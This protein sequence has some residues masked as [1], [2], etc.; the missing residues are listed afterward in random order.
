M[1]RAKSQLKEKRSERY[2]QDTKRREYLQRQ[3][4]LR[5]DLCQQTRLLDLQTLA[6]SVISASAQ[7][8]KKEKKNKKKKIHERFERKVELVL[9]QLSNPEWM[10]EIPSD[11]CQ[12]S[13]AAQDQGQGD[14][15]GTSSH[16]KYNWYVRPR[17][18]GKRCLVIASKGKTVSYLES[19]TV[20]H[21][22][23]SLLPGGGGVSGYGS[24]SRHDSSA[25]LDCIY[26]PA[27]RVYRILDLMNW[28]EMSCYECDAEFRLYWLQTKYS[29]TPGLATPPPIL[30]SYSFQLVPWWECDGNGLIQAYSAPLNYQRNGLLFYHREGH[31]ETTLTPLVLLWKDHHVTRYLDQS[32][33]E[34]QRRRIPIALQCQAMLPDSSDPSVCSAAAAA[35]SVPTESLVFVTLDQHPLL[36]ISAALFGREAGEVTVSPGD[37]LRGYVDAVGYSEETGQP[38][39]AGFALD[40]VSLCL[41]LLF[42]LSSSSPPSPLLSLSPLI[43]SAGVYRPQGGTRLLEQN[44]FQIFTSILSDNNRLSAAVPPPSASACSDRTTDTRHRRER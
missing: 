11:L 15:N 28:N 22:F 16:I 21:H 20:L 29:E 35:A 39:I 3:Q 17:P 6:V 10:T 37:L 5:R 33:G 9:N 14:G 12:Y 32:E 23:R 34:T 36:D 26:S 2:S 27:E 42:P 40:T 38:M 8:E 13:S 44:S 31:Y 41:V 4:I 18:E 24:N 25:I 1:E 19:G 43:S 30:H 7:G